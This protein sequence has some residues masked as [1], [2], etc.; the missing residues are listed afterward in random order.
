MPAPPITWVILT[1]GDRPQA[2][3]AAVASVTTLDG[4]SPQVVLVANGASLDP[5]QVPAGVEVRDLPANV[6]IPAGRNAGLQQAQGEIVFFLDDDAEVA[7]PDLVLRTIKAFANDED[8]AVVSFRLADPHSGETERRWVPRIRAGS[9]G[10]SSDVTTFLG[11]AC[12]MRASAV[13]AVGGYADEFFYAMEE[14]DLAW[15]LLD[16]GHRVHYMGDVMVHHPATSPGRHGQS[17]RLTAR[18]RVWLVRRRLPVPLAIG[19]LGVWSVLTVVRGRSVRAVR[20][21]VTGVREGFQ[22]DPGPRE[23]MSWS[24]VLRMTRMGRP[25]LI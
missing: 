18:N 23:P 22:G 5:G 7:S 3:A 10:R 25:P 12:A 15:R 11:G 19:Y 1:Q 4:P 14:S 17:A 16:A 6:G 21:F 13:N 20:D 24:T 9:P 8:L 2:L